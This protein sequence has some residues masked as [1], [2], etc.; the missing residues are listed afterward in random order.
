MKFKQEIHVFNLKKKF[1]KKFF[2]KFRKEI[3]IFSRIM[4]SSK[5]NF[6]KKFF[7]EIPSG[8]SCISVEKKLIRKKISSKKVHVTLGRTSGAFMNFFLTLRK[9]IVELRKLIVETFR[10]GI[11]NGF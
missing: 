8:N 2:R 10:S 5:E 3:R 6:C 7:L 11:K 9:L 1:W 4:I